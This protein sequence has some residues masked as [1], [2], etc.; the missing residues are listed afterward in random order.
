MGLYVY[1]RF[2]YGLTATTDGITI[3]ARAGFTTVAAVMDNAPGN[4]LIG[5]VS[6][7]YGAMSELGDETNSITQ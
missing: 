2:G 5:R 1:L 6:D 3:L 7:E 4:G